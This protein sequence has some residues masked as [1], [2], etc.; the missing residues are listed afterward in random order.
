MS[1]DKTWNIYDCDIVDFAEQYPEAA[2]LPKAILVHSERPCREAEALPKG[3]VTKVLLDYDFSDDG[4]VLE[5]TRRYGLV[6]CPYAGATDRT[7]MAIEDPFGYLRLLDGVVRERKDGDGDDARAGLWARLCGL[8][9]V[10][11]ARD[12][13]SEA[14]YSDPLEGFKGC[15]YKWDAK[16]VFYSGLTASSESEYLRTNMRGFLRHLEGDDKLIGTERLR[17]FAWNEAAMRHERTGEWVLP[18]CCVSLEEVRAVLYLLQMS[19]VVLQGF[20]Y[21]DHTP[22]ERQAAGILRR[23]IASQFLLPS[24]EGV[25]GETAWKN[26]YG[27]NR[28]A[29]TYQNARRVERLFQLFIMGRPNIVKAFCSLRGDCL[30]EYEEGDRE[31]MAP[32]LVSNALNEPERQRA[33]RILE[34]AKKANGDDPETL[35]LLDRRPVW[36]AWDGPQNLEGDLAIFLE[37]C[38]TNCWTPENHHLIEDEPLLVGDLGDGGPYFENRANRMTLQRAIAEQI[39]YQLGVAIKRLSPRQRANASDDPAWQVCTECGALFMFRS[40]TDR[41]VMKG[42]GVPSRDR[43]PSAET[44]SDRCRQRKRRAGR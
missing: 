34:E 2:E 39:R 37:A 15:E 32:G 35:R 24:F 23:Q 42:E 41:L 16:R 8:F 11:G 40:T 3:F 5:F 4:Q 29:G 38:L 18:P 9:R 13:D 33:Y 6:S 17:A 21:I 26:R 44:C 10:P 31:R 36:G 12:N 30:M 14:G 20:S 28:V 27:A 25:D 1:L 7:F 43:H 22:S 19:S